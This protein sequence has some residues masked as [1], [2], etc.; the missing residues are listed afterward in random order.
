MGLTRITCAMIAAG[1]DQASG[2]GELRSLPIGSDHSL[3]IQWGGQTW[4]RTR[5]GQFLGMAP[6]AT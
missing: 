3:A 6:R 1:G 4:D 2:K 5:S